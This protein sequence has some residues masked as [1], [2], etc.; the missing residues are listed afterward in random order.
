MSVEKTSL[1]GW[2]FDVEVSV[3]IVSGAGVCG[4]RLG[5]KWLSLGA[6]CV[7]SGE[8]CV[9]RGSFLG[10]KTSVV[11]FRGKWQRQAFSTGWIYPGISDSCVYLVPTAFGVWG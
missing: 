11:I 3:D 8:N 4:K 9:W 10:F 5:V 2:I 1:T 7:R 6:C